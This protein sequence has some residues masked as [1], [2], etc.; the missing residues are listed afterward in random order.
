MP[1]RKSIGP[2][3]IS[4][5][6]LQMKQFKTGQMVSCLDSTA[7]TTRET[8]SILPLGLRTRSS[9]ELA[10]SYPLSRSSDCWNL[11][12]LGRN[13]KFGGRNLNRLSALAEGARA[14]C[15]GPA[16]QCCSDDHLEPSLNEWPDQTKHARKIAGQ[17]TH[18]PVRHFSRSNFGR[19]SSAR[20]TQARGRQSDAE[21]RGG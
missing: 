18:R 9:I 12:E 2:N 19:C 5:C 11:C 7:T 13:T 6:A 1:T 8:T 21:A 17:Q 15:T 3:S 10:A 4:C 14:H 16:F 20:A